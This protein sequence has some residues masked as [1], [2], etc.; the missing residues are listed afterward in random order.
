MKRLSEATRHELPGAVAQPA[1]DRAACGIG[2]LHLGLG[3]FHRAHQAVYTDDVLAR[4]GGDRDWAIHGVSLRH[5]GVRDQLAPQ[6]GLYTV[7]ERGPA[8]EALRVIGAVKQVSFAPDAP[9]ALI[10][11]MAAPTTRI[12]SLTVTE[13]GYCHD[14]AS[15]RLRA[16][17]PDIVHDLAN[18]LR[19][20][21][22]LG[23]L[24]AGLKARKA[25]GATPF[26]VLC[27]DN[28]P[29]RDRTRAPGAAAVH[30]R[31]RRHRRPAAFCRRGIRR[32]A[33]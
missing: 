8:G 23:H 13:K 16:D 32:G 4:P 24:L 31:R 6:D 7:A 3:A 28:L 10:D 14:P 20:R 29:H 17:H 2:I 18:P 26:T 9:A 5:S 27:C 33:G 12:V 15:G 1:Y 21:T 25:A 22:V 11:L 30:R 19:P